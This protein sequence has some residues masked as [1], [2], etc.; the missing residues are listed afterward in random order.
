[1]VSPP[2]LVLRRVAR[3]ASSA[4]E[5]QAWWRRISRRDI[6]G[7]NGG[8]MGYGWDISLVI[9]GCINLN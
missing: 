7:V 8:F 4:S 1:M 5:T 3:V 9:G 2:T 6:H